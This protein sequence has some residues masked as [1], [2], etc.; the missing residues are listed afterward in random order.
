MLYVLALTPKMLKLGNSSTNQPLANLIF[1]TV[2]FLITSRTLVHSANSCTGDRPAFGTPEIAT[3]QVGGN[4][5]DFP[6]IIFNCILETNLPFS[7]GPTYH[8]CDEQKKISKALIEDPKLVTNISSTIKKVVEKGRKGPIKENFRL[9]VVGFP[10]F[11]DTTTKECDDVTFARTANPKPDGKE[12]TNLTQAIRQEFNDMSNGLNKAIAK[13][14]EENKDQNVKFIPIEKELQ[15]HRY[16]EP[17]VQEPNQ[18]NDKLWLWHYPYNEPKEPKDDPDLQ[19]LTDAYNKVMSD[20]SVKSK[21]TTFSSFENQVYDNIETTN[22]IIDRLWRSVGKRV[23]VFHPQPALHQRIRNYV[24]DQYTDDVKGSLTPAQTT[25]PSAPTSSPSRVPEKNECHGIGGDTWVM[26]ADTAIKNV[27]DFCNQNSKEVTY[28]QGSV[29]ELK[30]SVKAP[31]NE[32]KG[33]KDTPPGTNCATAFKN[34]VIGGCDGDDKVNNPHNYKFGG[35]FTS[36]DGWE[37]TMTPLSKQIN[38]VSCD[39]SYKFFFDSFEIRGKNLPE[40]K[41]GADGE[42]LKEEI[43]GCGALTKWNF[44]QT[45]DDVKFQWYASGQLPIGTKA[46]VG[47]ALQSAGGSGAGNC[48]GAGKRSVGMRDI[49]IEDWPG[50]GDDSKHIFGSATKRD[51]GIEDSEHLFGSASRRDVGIENWPDYSDDDRHVFGVSG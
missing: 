30:L 23:K 15:G 32:D 50:Y 10:Q 51:V 20:P 37:F 26:H 6:G 43:S 12:H 40:A 1:S 28:N 8:T 11:F 45:P 7:A 25:S 2:S 13:A 9:Y 41:L 31:N 27:D 4:N 16:C 35:T 34:A 21:F 48:H 3:L 17:G 36:S 29:D 24:L 33:P 38:E 46:C 5:I 18:K 42:G 49:G 47:R 22:P 39:V 19:P 44:E 14:V